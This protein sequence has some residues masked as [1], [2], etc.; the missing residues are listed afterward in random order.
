MLET[1]N[2]GSCD[3]SRHGKVLG[4]AAFCES[5]RKLTQENLGY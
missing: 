3:Y 5:L 4:G 1:P 2:C